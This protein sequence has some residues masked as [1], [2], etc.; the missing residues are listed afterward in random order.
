MTICNMSIEAGAR[1]GWSRPTTRPSRTSKDGPARPPGADWEQALDEWRAPALGR[2]RRLRPG[3]RD[4]RGSLAPAGHLGDEPGHGRA[5]GRRRPRSGLLRGRGRPRSAERA[6]EY[7]ALEPGTPIAEIRV[8]RV[9]IG[10]CTNARIEDLRVVAGDRRREEGAPDRARDG[11]P[12]LGR[13]QAA[14][15]GG[16]TRRGVPAGGLRVAAGRLLDVPRHE[17]RHPRAG[18]ALRV[19]LEPQLRGPAGARR[20]DA[21]R[22]PGDGGRGRARRAGS[23]T[24]ARWRREGVPQRR[25]GASPS[26]TAPDVDTDQIIPKQFLKRIE[27]TGYGEFLFFDWR[28]DPDVRAEPA[29]V[30]GRVHPRR[31]PELRLRLV[32]R[33]RGLGAPGLRL[34]GRDRALVR[35]H[36]RRE[37]GADRPAH[38]RS[39]RGAGA[40]ARR[41]RRELTVDLETRRS[42]PDGRTIRLR[43]RPV[44]AHKLLNGLD[45][46]GLTLEHEAEIAAFESAH[47]A[48]LDTTALPA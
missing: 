48:R 16:G 11:R 34:R 8:D 39:A 24:S 5:G 17:P 3:G 23:R 41:R 15:R 28:K 32:A 47:P 12:G 46:I 18:R 45:D 10:S 37:L 9:F 36:L 1:A 14:G 13:G 30:R 44:P 40:R 35:R 33:A 20:A 29:R 42:P 21:S 31:G 19:D 2:R 7:M 4:R 27:R 26:S 38:G 43:V 6:L 25:P 22:Q